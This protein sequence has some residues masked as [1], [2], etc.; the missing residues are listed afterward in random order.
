M[1]SSGTETVA[2]RVR[3]VLDA[4]RRAEIRAGR[5]PGA[6]QLVAVTKTVP[7]ER[8]REGIDAGLSLLG[9]N[10]LQEAQ[11]KMSTLARA[12]VRWHF[13][14]HL[15]RRKARSVIGRFE[16][17]HSLDSVE[18]AREIDGRAGEAG[19]CQDV[20]L[21]VNLGGEPTK[22]GFPPDALVAA[23]PALALLP[24][25]RIRGLMAIPPPTAEA[26]QARPYFRRLRD[27]ARNIGELH[28]PTVAMADLSMGMSND[29]EIAVEEGATLV[30]VGTALFG[31]RA[32]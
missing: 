1:N 11:A 5:V 25:I 6:V 4:I 10:R 13:I 14:G 29:Y 21:E 12:P 24:H 17:I 23:V 2:E 16:L 7:L 32:V 28:L 15:Q 31:V 9:E 20:L 18:L 8:I 27:L 3:R 22:S 19:V 30:R 26:E